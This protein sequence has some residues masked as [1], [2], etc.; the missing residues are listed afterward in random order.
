M[1]ATA[2]SV[3]WLSCQRSSGLPKPMEKRSTLTPQ[4][5]ATQKW[6]N[7]CTAT[8]IASVSSVMRIV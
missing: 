7:S 3:P 4:R 6:P 8:R 1:A 2:Y 5:R